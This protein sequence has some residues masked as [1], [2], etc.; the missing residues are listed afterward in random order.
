M[1]GVRASSTAPPLVRSTAL[2]A[3]RTSLHIPRVPNSLP[4]YALP[5]PAF[6]FPH[7]ANLAGRAPIGGAR[8]V[9]LACFVAARLAADC[10]AAA[11]ELDEPGRAA[12]SAGAKGW[13]GTLTLPPAL[14]ASLLRC[15]ESTADGSPAAISR[16]LNELAMAGSGY[17]DAGSRAELDALVAALRT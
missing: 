13:L 14:R 10:S 2:P 3:P 1:N 12:R 8:E 6:P 4:P 17:L 16:E 7:L 15:L 5:S 11:P 9:A